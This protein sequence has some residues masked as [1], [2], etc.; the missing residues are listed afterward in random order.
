MIRSY[1]ESF[2][3][4]KKELIAPRILNIFES[5]FDLIIQDVEDVQHQIGRF[6]VEREK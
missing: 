2:Q 6:P 3:F 5:S 4:P 1:H